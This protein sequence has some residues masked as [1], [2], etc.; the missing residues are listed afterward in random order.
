MPKKIKYFEW[1]KGPALI[2]PSSPGYFQGLYLS[3]ETNEW[4]A[5]NVLQFGD[6]YENGDLID[7]AEFEARFGKIGIN[8]PD[9]KLTLSLRRHEK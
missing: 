5:A 3:F 7:Q 6:F 2:I 1:N 9:Y 4:T 8:L